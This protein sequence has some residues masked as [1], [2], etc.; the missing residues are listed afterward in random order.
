MTTRNKSGTFL[1]TLEI[2][3]KVIAKCR[4]SA[5]GPDGI[6]FSMYRNMVDI[7]APIFLDLILHMSA[8]G[9]PNSSFNFINLFF[10]PKGDSNH[11]SKL[12]PISVSNS[13][14]RIIANLVHS[15]TTPAIGEILD[16]SQRCFLALRSIEDHIL[17]VN[18]AFH[19][20]L[21]SKSDL[22]V[23]LNDFEK[24]YESASRRF[25]FAVLRKVGAP[26]WIVRILELLFTK[27]L[28]LPCPFRSP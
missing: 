27:S 7:F 16:K 13:D 19:S 20:H 14:N 10:F 9:R 1:S 25:L 22:H 21:E 28:R 17:E 2:V 4:D 8:V 5:T 26:D 11:P 18:Q 3:T 15:L 6:P 23:L 12:R 24:A